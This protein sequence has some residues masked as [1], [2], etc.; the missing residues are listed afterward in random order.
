MSQSRLLDRTL[1]GL[2][3]AGQVGDHLHHGLAGRSDPGGRIAGYVATPPAGYAESGSD[4]NPSASFG[5]NQVD[6]GGITRLA[7]ATA[8][9]SVSRVG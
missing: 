2:S 9:R 6:F 1:P 5:S 3:R 8:I 7:S 4:S